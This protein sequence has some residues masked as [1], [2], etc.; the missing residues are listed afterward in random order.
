MKVEVFRFLRGG[1]ARKLL[2]IWRYTISAT[3]VAG[4]GFLLMALQS[5]AEGRDPPRSDVEMGAVTMLGAFF[6]AICLA[7]FAAA[8]NVDAPPRRNYG[9]NSYPVW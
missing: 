7:V 5:A 4:M 6:A 2:A 8:S 3:V 9:R 1:Q